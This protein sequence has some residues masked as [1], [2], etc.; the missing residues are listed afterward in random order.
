MIFHSKPLHIRFGKV[1]GFVRVYDGTKYFVLCELEKHDAI[2][3]RI[4]S[5]ISKK[6]GITYF[7]YYIY[8]KIKVDSYN[9]LTL[10]NINFP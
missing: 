6:N 1:D 2:Y 7:I 8:E 4:R 10:K 5:L 9:S 3:N